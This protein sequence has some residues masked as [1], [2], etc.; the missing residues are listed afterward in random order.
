MRVIP[1]P[2]NSDNF[3]YLVFNEETN[4]GFWVDVSMQPNK[5]FEILKS[6]GVSV[7]HVLTTHKHADHAGGNAEFKELLGG[8]IEIFGSA[9][10]AVEAC[11][12]L[13]ADKDTL[14]ISGMSITCLLTP[15]H[16]QGHVSYFVEHN[17]DK[18]V[19]TGDV[20]FIGGAGR[21]FEGTAEDMYFSL[22]EQL[23]KLPSGI[24]KVFF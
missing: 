1:T 5:C 13:V 19:F 14:Q 7:K 4:E 2:L 22:F 15:G 24:L 6:Y 3:G 20:L 11:T 21:F 9:T 10:D 16:T 18:V 23:G 17:G 8:V 12:N